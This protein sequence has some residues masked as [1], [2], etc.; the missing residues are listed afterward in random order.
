MGISEFEGFRLI[1]RCASRSNK[2][3]CPMLRDVLCMC[4]DRCP[5]LRDVVC[6]CFG[7]VERSRSDLPAYKILSPLSSPYPLIYGPQV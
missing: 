2:M 5:I 1:I 3:W 6:V 7:G 4:A